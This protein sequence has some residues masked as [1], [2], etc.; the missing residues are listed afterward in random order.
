MGIVT[1][2]VGSK[3]YKFKEPLM[4]EDESVDGE[5]RLVRTDIGLSA[6]GTSFREC[7]GAIRKQLVELWEGFALAPDADLKDKS[8][9]FKH[10]LLAMVEEVK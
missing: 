6:S 9:A 5:I 2:T 8:L 4:L 1:F 3:V 10:K 7:E